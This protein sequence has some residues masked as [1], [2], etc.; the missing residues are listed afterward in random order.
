[1]IETHTSPEM[2]QEEAHQNIWK[3]G[4]IMIALGI[5][6]AISRSILLALAIVQFLWVV[7]TR[8]KNAAISDF[9]TSMSAWIAEVVKFQ[10]FATEERPFPWAPWPR[11]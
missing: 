1:M 8:E 9:G 2:P 7:F 10:T 5:F 3:R 6:F 4:L 11:N